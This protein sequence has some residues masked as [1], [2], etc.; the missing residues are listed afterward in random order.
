[1]K[2]FFF[3]AAILTSIHSFAQQKQIVGTE[4]DPFTYTITKSKTFT[5]ATVVCA[6]PLASEIG[7]AI[8]K[9]GGN[10]FDAAIAVNFALEVVY[11]NAGN[12]GGGGLLTAR[13]SDGKLITLD[14]R[15]KAPAG[16]SRN[17]YLDSAG[18]VVPDLSINGHLSSGVPG[19]VAGMFY[20]HRWAKLPMSVLVQPAIDLA[21]NGYAVTESEANSLNNNKEDFLKFNTMPVA[22]VKDGD[23]KPGDT[24]IQKELAQTLVRIRDGGQKGFYEGETAKLIVEEMKRGKWHLNV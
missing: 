7:V 14:Y 5:Q 23:W 17:M 19:T 6:H 3:I 2:R 15:E 21:M 4:V 13:K 9:R 10:A 20:M 18:N 11:P 1:M 22:Y 12:I 8:M 24:L 16:A